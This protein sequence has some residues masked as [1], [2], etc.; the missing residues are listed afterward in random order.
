MTVGAVMF[1][2]SWLDSGFGF[3]PREVLTSYP[4]GRR[5]ILEVKLGANLKFWVWESS[6]VGTRDGGCC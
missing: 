5:G 3:I 1:R 2:S 6:I 4:V